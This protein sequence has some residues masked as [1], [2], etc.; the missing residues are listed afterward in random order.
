MM[1]KPVT[2]H[3]CPNPACSCHHQF[4]K[5]TII[6]HSLY[7]TKQGKRRRYRCKVCGTTFCSTTGKA[8]YK[9]QKPRSTFDEVVMMSVNG[10]SK[11]AIARIKQLSWN[12]VAH[13]LEI[14]SRFAFRFNDRLTRGYVLTEL[15]ADEIRTFVMSKKTPR[16]ILTALEVW[17]RLWVGCVIGRRSYKNIRQLLS[18]VFR[19]G[20]FHK[21]FMFTT[22][23]YELYE[24]AVKRLF[25]GY[26]Y[27]WSSDKDPT[28]QPCDP[29]RAETHN[30]HPTATRQNVDG[31]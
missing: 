31:F 6:R 17:S 25:P 3:C 23:G 18:Y 8:Y 21:P 14:A 13:W 16:W 10:V 24:W 28:E 12:T 30:R 9:L 19:R 22:D 27:L 5:G 15:Q 1:R 4:R 29:G 20:Q 26:L 2:N 7:K 11:S